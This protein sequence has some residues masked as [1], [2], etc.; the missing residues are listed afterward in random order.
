MPSVFANPKLGH[1]TSLP[2]TFLR[3]LHTVVAAVLLTGCGSDELGMKISVT[4]I[5]APATIPPVVAETHAGKLKIVIAGVPADQA[6]SLAEALAAAF[7]TEK[8]PAGQ[9]TFTKLS[10][11][12]RSMEHPSRASAEIDAT[13]IWAE[14][15][16]D[17]V[18]FDVSVRTHS[19]SLED[20]SQL[21][22]LRDEAL[23]GMVVK[24]ADAL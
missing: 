10:V 4:E 21:K 14:D 18:G 15:G 5:P 23:K 8:P 11:R 12:N 16:D 24:L 22:Y 1:G 6:P 3:A 19:I 9:L 13:C 20:Q 7:N 2:M 17:T